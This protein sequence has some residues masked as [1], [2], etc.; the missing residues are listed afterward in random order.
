MGRVAS[1]AGR[2]LV[3]GG[4]EGRAVAGV[5]EGGLA[6]G[7]RKAAGGGHADGRR[8]AHGHV[9]DARGHLAPGRAG[10]VA[11]VVRQ[12]EL[13]DQHHRV[14]PDLDRLDAQL[15]LRPA[16]RSAGRPCAGRRRL[17]GRRCD[18][19]APRRPDQRPSAP[20]GRCG[21]QVPWSQEAR[22]FACSA[23]SVSMSTPMVASL[24]RAISASI[25]AGTS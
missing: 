2:R 19:T 8:A 22:Y 20:P 14:G 1:Q 11:L 5:G 13:V 4:V 10:D 23:V 25:S 17:R 15:V 18:V 12:G 7:Q 9:A 24:S 3:E 21:S 16:G 6:G